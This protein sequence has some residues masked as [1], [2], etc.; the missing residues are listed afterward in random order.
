MPRCKDPT[1]T[2]TTKT[3]ISCHISWVV[4]LSRIPVTT[5]IISFFSRGSTLTF[6]YH[7]C[8]EG[9]ATQVMMVSE[10]LKTRLL[11][12]F[13]TISIPISCI[14]PYTSH[15]HGRFTYRTGCGTCFCGI[16]APLFPLYVKSR[17]HWSIEFTLPQSASSSG[18]LYNQEAS[19]T[20]W[21]PTTWVCS[22]CFLIKFNHNSTRPQTSALT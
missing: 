19:N 10:G 15:I 2:T 22:P 9:G 4:P 5:K 14:S 16:P 1:T 12:M 6:I 18:F 17:I 3:N 11:R 8:W 20:F 21:L 7:C 13:F